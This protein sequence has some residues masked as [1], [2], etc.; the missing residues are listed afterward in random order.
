MRNTLRVVYDVDGEDYA[1]YP[2]RV[3]IERPSGETELG[4]TDLSM[5][6]LRGSS[7]MHLKYLKNMGVTSTMVIAIIVNKKLWGLYSFHGYREPLVP[8]ARTRFLCEMASITTS[9][10]MESLTRKEDNDRLMKLESAMNTISTMTLPDFFQKNA[11]EIM[12]ALDVNLISFRVRDPPQTPVLRTY[13]LNDAAPDKQ[14]E[15][16]H[17][18]TNE[19]FDSLTET[20]APVCRDYGIVYIDEQKSNALLVD[21]HIHTLVFFQTEGVDVILSRSRTV[22]RV[23][24]GGDPDKK[25][26]PDGTLTPRNSFAAYVKSHF[27]KGKPWDQRDRQL[28]SR[29]SDQLEKHRTIELN[30]EHTRTIMT[31]EQQ[32]KEVA[33]MAK[34]NFDFF[35]VSCYV[36]AG[37]I[38]GR[39]FSSRGS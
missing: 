4:Y 18:L 27:R 23:T 38:L 7:Y 32:K 10:I 16:T 12:R 33:D 25:L 24:W 22:E 21:M 3:E 11:P 1:L 13:A 28:I 6:R 37:S 8:S 34:V 17:E 14:L 26:E 30:V 2:P 15:P 29:F 9:I 36:E 20:Y 19:V 31:L 5:C 35:A 39:C